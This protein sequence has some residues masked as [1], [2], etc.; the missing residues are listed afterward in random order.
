MGSPSMLRER[1]EQVL[2]TSEAEF[3]RIPPEDLQT[4]IHELDVHQVELEL[5]NDELLRVQRQLQKARDRFASLYD[6]TPVSYVTLDREGIIREANLTAAQLLGDNRAD[7]IGMPFSGFIDVDDQDVWYLYRREMDGQPPQ[8]ACELRVRDRDRTLTVQLDCQIRYNA[9]GLL[10]SIFVT[11]TDITRRKEMEQVEKLQEQLRQATR[12]STIGQTAATIAHEI[13]QPLTVVT[14]YAAV[15][16]D[17]LDRDEI[18]LLREPLGQLY[19]SAIRTTEIVRRLR[20]LVRSQKSKRSAL[21]VNCTIREVLTLFSSELETCELRLRLESALP[22]IQADAI[23]IEEVLVNLIRNAL[24][25]MQQTPEAE[26]LLTIAA[27]RLDAHLIEV[28]VADTGCGFPEERIPDLFEPYK[29][30]KE[31]GLGLGLPISRSIIAAHGG[32]L[33][34]EANLEL[35]ANFKL[36]LPASSN[37]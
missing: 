12:V 32:E 17:L 9:R 5:Q 31:N 18:E 25:A 23:Q 16:L 6:L 26:R 35:G 8:H 27:A 14:N 7:L 24:D 29:T 28:A 20:A 36:R 21:D 13:N 3:A 1:A 2:R 22:P 4:L 33:F 10:N 15:C 30:T 11:L 19:D 34:A 37:G